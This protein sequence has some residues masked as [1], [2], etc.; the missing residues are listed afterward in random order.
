M[1]VRNFAAG[2][3]L[4]SENTLVGGFEF[5]DVQG[6]LCSGAVIDGAPIRVS[7][8]AMAGDLLALLAVFAIIFVAGRR[9]RPCASRGRACP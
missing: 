7:A 3:V 1:T 4:I 8:K 5:T 6:P 2:D 9:R